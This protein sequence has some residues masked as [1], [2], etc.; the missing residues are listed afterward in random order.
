[1]RL[2]VNTDIRDI[3]PDAGS[4]FFLEGKYKVEDNENIKIA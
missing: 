3:E 4:D 1:M 2:E